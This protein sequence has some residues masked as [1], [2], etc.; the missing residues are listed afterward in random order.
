M[1]QIRWAEGAW[2][3]LVLL[4]AV[5]MAC[6]LADTFTFIVEPPTYP[7][8][9]R[10]VLL[11]ALGFAGAAVWVW[12]RGGA[13]WVKVLTALPA[14]VVG[15]LA[16]QFEDGGWGWLTGIFL[17]PAALA[18]MLAHLRHPAGVARHLA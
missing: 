17:I 7:V 10:L 5:L 15:G 6:G 2:A 11:G 12:L 8:G 13:L 1:Y 14:V 9:H 4:S 3:L 18:A 16:L